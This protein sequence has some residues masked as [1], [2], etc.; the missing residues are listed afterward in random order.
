VITL[1]HSDA[2]DP[3][4]LWYLAARTPG[5]LA[6][7]TPTI[8]PFLEGRIGALDKYM[9]D[10]DKPEEAG[11]YHVTD[12]VK[13]LW[14]EKKVASEAFWEVFR[15]GTKS[16][17]ELDAG[18]KQ[19]RKEYFEQASKAWEGIK[20]PLVKLNKELVG[21]YVLGEHMRSTPCAR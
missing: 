4:S 8:L 17:G 6:A 14:R 2:L 13:M 9:A 12:K 7:L 19:K 15:Y 16:E 11:G 1:V 3:V 20:V 10:A 5:E 21:P 18:S